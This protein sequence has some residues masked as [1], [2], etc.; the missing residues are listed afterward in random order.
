MTTTD[1]SK[2][3]INN[4]IY[5]VKD[6]AGRITS[7]TYDSSNKQIILKSEAGNVDIDLSALV[8]SIPS[9]Y[10]VTVASAKGVTYTTTGS[11]LQ[12]G[13]GVVILEPATGYTLPTTTSG[14][15]SAS[16]G[17]IQYYVVFDE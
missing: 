11:M 16:G 10:T 7:G 12:S 8:S 3:K 1:I 14:Y 6:T 17:S 9:M 15:I 5:A 4:E 13:Q 2:I